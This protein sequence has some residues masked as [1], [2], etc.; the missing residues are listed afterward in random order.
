MGDLQTLTDPPPRS[1]RGI[2]EFLRSDGTKLP[3]L[4]DPAPCGP[5]LGKLRQGLE[6]EN[7]QAVRLALQ[8]LA[9][10]LAAHYSGPGMKVEVRT[11][12]RPH[13]RLHGRLVGCKYGEYGLRDRVAR[14]WM[15]TAVRRRV[16][17]FRTLL[18]TF[19]HEFGHHLDVHVL[20]FPRTYHTRGFYERFDALFYRLLAEEPKP[21][22]WV[23]AG[24]R[25]RLTRPRTQPWPAV[26]FR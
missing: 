15:Y 8:R 22:V 25:Y 5:D 21:L 4:P 2:E 16:V 11:R 24:R 17:A 23:P 3:A 14:V 7:V 19:L 6:Q 13:R 10:H 26:R 12:A 18:W 1:A 9:D 20:G